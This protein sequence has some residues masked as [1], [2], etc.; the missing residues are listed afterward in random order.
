MCWEDWE[1]DFWGHSMAYNGFTPYVE[2]QFVQPRNHGLFRT[3][4][5]SYHSIKPSETEC[6]QISFQNSAIDMDDQV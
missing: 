4:V 5:D 1:F 3:G 6:L 2:R